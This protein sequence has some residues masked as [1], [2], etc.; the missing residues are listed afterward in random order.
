MYIIIKINASSNK[1]ELSLAKYNTK[2]LASGG[3]MA[4]LVIIGTMIVQVP[5]P[6]KGYIHIGDSM[7]YLCGILLGPWAGGMAAAV[8]SGFADMFSGYGIYAPATFFIKGIDALAVGYCYKMIVFKDST[9]IKKS[10]AFIVA[11]L[12]GGTI[13][14]L[15]YLAYETFLYGFPIAVL[16][17]VG[18]ITQAVGGGVLALPLVLVLERVKI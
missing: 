17:I 6:T 11:F 18:N 4:A 12:I 2:Q 5:T 14:V 15:G 9:V 10:I 8:G 7:V 1:G 13:M 16:G 3:L